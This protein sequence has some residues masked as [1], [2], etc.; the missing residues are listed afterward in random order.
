MNIQ[1]IPCT[2]HKLNLVVRNALSLTDNDVNVDGNIE[3]NDDGS[4][5]SRLKE[6]LKKCRNIVGFFKRSEVGNRKLVEKQQ[7]M[8]LQNILKLKQDVCTRWN[9]TLVMMERLVQLK[10]SITIVIMTLKE[11]PPNLSPDE[12]DVVEDCIPLLKPFHSI[13]VE[14]SAEEYP[15]ISK[16][17]PLI[18][19]LQI[20][21][22]NKDPST[23]IGILL[24]SNL[25]ENIRSRFQ[26]IEKQSLVPHFGRATL[27]DPRC[28]KVAFKNE[29]NASDA[30]ASITAEV[31]S[32]LNTPIPEPE[33]VH[34]VQTETE[35]LW[36]FLTTKVNDMQS[37]STTTSCAMVLVKQYL[38]MPYQDLSCKLAE[39]WEKHK[40]LLYPLNEVALKYASIPA[41]SV[42]SERIFSKTGQ[43]MSARRNRLLPENLD[44]LVFLNKNM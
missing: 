8:G 29:Q 14:L 39:Y 38:G 13:T 18:R 19:G 10:E 24:K 15:T 3:N 42:P 41:T 30:E 33:V 25:H 17:I 1:H 34:P 20:A 21:L 44:T 28:K 43:I 27:L 2:A 37:Q 16:V 7:Q 35:D 4:S 26:G 40:T 32:L 11:A 36:G 9:S 6:I 31:A 22:T 12:W 23:I 5:D